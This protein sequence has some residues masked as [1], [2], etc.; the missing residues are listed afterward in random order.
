M[1]WILL[2]ALLIIVIFFM[3]VFR[4]VSRTEER[5]RE[6]VVRTELTLSR[7]YGAKL[8]PPGTAHP[9]KEKEEEE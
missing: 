2:G 4:L 7:R 8:V 5:L 6:L 1:V 3:M 9:D